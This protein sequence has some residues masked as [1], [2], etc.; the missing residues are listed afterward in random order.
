MVRPFRRADALRVLAA[1]DTAAESATRGPAA[2]VHALRATFEELPGEQTW[3]VAARAGAQAYS[4]IRRDVL[5]PLGP[6]G[7]RPYADLTGEVVIGPFALVTRPA[8]EPRIVD[9]PEWPGRKDLEL[10]WRFPE[11]YVSAQFKYGSIFYGQMERNW[12]P[13]GL[14]GIGV[15]NYGYPQVEAG[16]RIG[17][18]RVRARGAGPL[19]HRWP[20]HAVAHAHGH[21]GRPGA[22]L[23]LRTPGNRAIEQPVSPGTLGD[24]GIVGRRP[25]LRRP[26][27]EPAQSPAAGQPV[28]PRRRRQ[29][30][31]R[32]RRALAGER[33]DHA[34]GAA[35]HR[36]PAVREQL[37]SRPLPQPLGAHRLRLRPA[38]PRAWLAGVLY[39]GVEPRLPHAEP[40]RELHGRRCRPRPQLRRHGPAHAH[41]KRAAGHALAA[42]ARAHAAPAGRGQ[43]RRSVSRDFA[44]RRARFRSSSSASSSAPGAPRSISVAAR[45]RSTCT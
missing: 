21:P 22:P 15:S 7:V 41:R 27:P 1:A 23:L 6:D 33:P 20:R 39:S 24:G 14:P 2:I 25:R 19:A 9:D 30:D 29:R 16:F 44:A 42:D 31:V 11:A 32:R 35:R 12:G 5:H 4:H 26:L 36:R 37:G 34:R 40:V 3:R 13:V 38:W 18:R 43:D 45:A 8:A 10:A 28:R 17:T